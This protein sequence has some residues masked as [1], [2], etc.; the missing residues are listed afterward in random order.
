MSYGIV[1]F[2]RNRCAL[3]SQKSAKLLCFAILLVTTVFIN[4]VV[5]S[6]SLHFL[7]I[8]FAFMFFLTIFIRDNDDDD[9]DYD[10]YATDS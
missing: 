5:N 4:A 6:T 8:G 3:Q 2:L 10:S 7:A 1:S 9:Y